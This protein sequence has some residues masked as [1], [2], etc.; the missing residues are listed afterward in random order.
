MSNNEIELLRNEFYRLAGEVRVLNDKLISAFGNND[1][2]IDGVAF[3]VH[4]LGLD[5]N[6]IIKEMKN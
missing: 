2:R 1:Q 4:N 3:Q 6:Y 5:L